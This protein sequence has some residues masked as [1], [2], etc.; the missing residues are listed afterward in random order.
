MSVP[1]DVPELVTAAAEQRPD[2]LAVVEA[3]GRGLT[4]Q[5]L[6]D[7]VARTATGLG[8][9]G[10]VAGHRVLIALGN[11]LEFIVAYLG[12]LRAQAV[13]V[14]VNPTS[15]EDELVRMIADSG[16]RLA[17]GDAATLPLLRLAVRRVL[18]ARDHQDD[19]QLDADLVERSVPTRIVV[20][21]EP[22]QEGEIGYADL[23]EGEIR[24]VPPLL[25]PD[26][27]AVLL[28]TSGTSGRP[29]SSPVTG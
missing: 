18:A 28:Y 15:T 17:L 5:E 19:A 4:W 6:E 29:A 25:D 16:S 11:R 20:L 7:Q 26:K 24:P 1:H 2:K 8:R 21:D 12:V 10:I 23:A 9:H 22:A 13:A 14:P 27:L 3:D